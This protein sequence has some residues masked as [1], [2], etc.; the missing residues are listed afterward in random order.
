MY[1]LY[2]F[3]IMSSNPKWLGFINPLLIGTA[4]NWIR[5]N[6][7][8]MDATMRIQWDLPD[9]KNLKLNQWYFIICNH[10]SWVDI[11]VLHRIFLMK[12]PF[13]RFFIKKELN[14]LPFLN[15]AWWAYDFPIMHRHSK[16]QIEKNPALRLKDFQAT[17]KACKKYQMMPV[18]VL[19][20][21]EGTRFTPTKHK[22][23]NSHYQNLLEPKAGGFAFAI[24]VMDQKITR[25]LDVT[26]FYPEGTK[27]Y[28]DYLCGRIHHIKIE[29]LEREIP[30]QL[31]VGNYHDDEVYRNQFKQ[32]IK[33]IWEEKDKL[34]SNLKK[35]YTKS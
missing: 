25:V 8:M 28:W 2:C 10:Q 35:N 20:F 11:M 24:N 34:L 31:L 17:E 19:N 12:A 29:L 33:D 27:T 30:Q 18:T 14:W 4:N 15:L 13:I 26:I 16:E 7:L 1:V 32:W 21:L 6:N 22:M 5:T 23:Q 9:F 3:K